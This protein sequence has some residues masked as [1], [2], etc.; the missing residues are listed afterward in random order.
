[1][2]R[3]ES[4][5]E[6]YPPIE[7]NRNHK[8]KRFYLLTEYRKS[9]WSWSLRIRLERDRLT[10]R[11]DPNFITLKTFSSK[12][13]PC[14]YRNNEVSIMSN[15]LYPYSFSTQQ[16]PNAS[17]SDQNMYCSS[18]YGYFRREVS[19]QGADIAPSLWFQNSF[20]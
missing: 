6:M 8:Q 18:F 15:V 7:V 14:R 20:D 2:L 10:S 1:M 4:R 19:F 13:N 11:F 9:Y 12:F 5:R 17:S 3:Y 16:Y